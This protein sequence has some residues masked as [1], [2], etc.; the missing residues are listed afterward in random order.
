MQQQQPS[1][2]TLAAAPPEKPAP[3]CVTR[4]NALVRRGQTLIA[5]LT[6]A[7]ARREVFYALGLV[8]LVERSADD[9][10]R[11]PPAAVP[12]HLPDLLESMMALLERS[13]PLD[14]PAARLEFS[15]L[16][17]AAFELL[18]V[19]LCE[20]FGVELPNASGGG[21]NSATG[22]VMERLQ[23][24]KPHVRPPSRLNPFFLLKEEVNGAAHPR[25]SALI[26]T[27][28][29]LDAEAH[30]FCRV[31]TTSRELLMARQ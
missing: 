12:A 22:S 29:Q 20:H 31:V 14:R 3:A 26:I 4:L 9:C 16:L 10:A 19:R 18:L 21:R 28:D 30:A 23:L 6:D 1:P 27:W 2:S 11:M 25:S 17:K 15:V 8:A 5:G 13:F 7:D 24:L